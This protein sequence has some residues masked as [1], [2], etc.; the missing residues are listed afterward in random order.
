[1]GEGRIRDKEGHTEKEVK[2]SN[3]NIPEDFEDAQSIITDSCE[4]Q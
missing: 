4:I 1:M 2:K 3:K